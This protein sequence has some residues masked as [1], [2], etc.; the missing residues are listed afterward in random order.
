MVLSHEMAALTG[1][2][3]LQ[4]HGYARRAWFSPAQ[5]ATLVFNG[6]LL[7]FG[8]A[9]SQRYSL[10]LWLRSTALVLSAA[11][12]ALLIFGTLQINGYALKP[13]YSPVVWL[14]SSEMELSD[15]LAALFA[16]GSLI[17]IGC[18]RRTWYSQ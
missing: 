11:L 13:W 6:T 16:R 2:G 14:R 8:Y 4:F 12:A 5:L 3:A 18:A 10:Q 1:F 15:S 17:A 7:A 9:R